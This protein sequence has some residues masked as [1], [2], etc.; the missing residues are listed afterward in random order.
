MATKGKSV[1]KGAKAAPKKVAKKVVKKA[2]PKPSNAFQ[3]TKLKLLRPVPSDI[4]IA[5]A[6]KLKTI[7]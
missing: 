3:P 5:Q 4:E 6:G 7:H 2:A 1:K